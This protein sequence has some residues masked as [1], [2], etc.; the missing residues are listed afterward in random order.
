MGNKFDQLVEEISAAVHEEWMKNKRLK[1]VTS[2]PSETGEELMVP[3]DQ[4]SEAAKDLDRG[5]V[6]AVLTAL[7]ASGHLHLDD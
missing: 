4:L 6:R 5:S 2:R 3:Y 1:G 7:F